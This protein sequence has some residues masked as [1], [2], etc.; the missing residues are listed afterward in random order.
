MEN[1]RV[2]DIS[3]QDSVVANEDSVSKTLQVILLIT[4]I[5]S[6]FLVFNVGGYNSFIPAELIL[7]T[8]ATVVGILIVVTLVLYRAKGNLNRYWK[9][10]CSFL[11]ASIGLLF[12][13]IFGRWYS[14]IPGLIP[15]TVEGAAIAKVA[16]VLPIILAILAG[17]WII[18]RDFSV[19]YLNGGNFR[20]SI[21]L[22]IIISPGA[23]FVFVA[24]GGLGF[25][26]TANEVIA[27]MP[28]I[29]VFALSNALM[30]ELLI[31]GLFLRKY[32]SI[33]GQRGA[34]ILTSVIFALFHQAIIGFMDILSM[35]AY[36][37]IPLIMGILWG[38]I[39][40]K[41]DNIWGAVLAHMIADIFFVLVM[42]G[43]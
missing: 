21:K 32:E 2:N 41:S 30:E 3:D 38:Y 37:S 33:F 5:A 16:E 6:S 43:V 10:S 42:F 8:R 24:L 35:A 39:I 23:L 22:G 13:W 12:A 31:R 14:L 36:F 25:S 4:F 28:W 40:Q 29:C 26:A 15:D 9:V 18:E 17:V 7:L 20:Q 27:W 11:V 34:L 19:I 1:Q